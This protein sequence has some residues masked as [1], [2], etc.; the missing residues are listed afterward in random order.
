MRERSLRGGGW[1]FERYHAF[2]R[3]G[4]YTEGGIRFVLACSR[5]LSSVTYISKM[6]NDFEVDRLYIVD[7]PLVSARGSR[8]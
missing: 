5:E 1:G 4:V 2:A 3:G 8:W 6:E 7:N